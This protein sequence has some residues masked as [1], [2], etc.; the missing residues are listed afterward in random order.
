MINKYLKWLYEK[1]ETESVGSFAIDSFPTK[2]SKKPLPVIYSEFIDLD[3]LIVK[4]IMIDF[5]GTIHKYSEGWK[6]GTIYDPPFPG[7]KEVI[8]QF[9]KDGFEIVIFTSRLCQSV[10]N[11]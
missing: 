10:H 9:K 4:R 11:Q 6:D 2:A 7:V 3:N 5:D 1:S 8:N